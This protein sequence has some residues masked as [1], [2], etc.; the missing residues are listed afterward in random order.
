MDNYK[1]MQDDPEG[2]RQELGRLV[3]RGFAVYL[4]KA[5]A[6]EHFHRATLS[7]LALTVHEDKGHWCKEAEDHHRPPPFRW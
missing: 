3:E 6:R 7:R 4:T 2:A 5:E 1:S